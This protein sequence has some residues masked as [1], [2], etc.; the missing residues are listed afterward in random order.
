[1]ATKRRQSKVND[2]QHRL[3][4]QKRKGRKDY[5]WN[6]VDVP[7]EFKRIPIVELAV[8]PDYQRTG[9]V[10]RPRVDEIRKNW[11][12]IACGTLIVAVR[13]D[14]TY[15]VV[16]GQHRLLGAQKRNDIE[17]LP[18]LVFPV[19]ELSEEALGFYR[20]NTVRGAVDQVTKFKARLT[21]KDPEAEAIH[22]LV[23]EQGYRLGSSSDKTVDCMTALCDAYKSS[24][25]IMADVWALCV[26]LHGGKHIQANVLKA[27]FYLERFLVQQRTGKS[28]LNGQHLARMK[29]LGIPII[30]TQMSTMR[31]ALGHG[32]SKVGAQTLVNLLNHNRTAQYRLPIVYDGESS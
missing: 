9:R 3:Q 8:D 23:I 5:V 27:L 2:G 18:C 29:T 11:S 21:A 17:S 31:K 25:K 24:P 10:C 6:E 4:D 19:A 15:W 32:G 14:G 7:G 13:G 30:N 28:I 16:D 26:D 12:W 1:M 20:V 22:K